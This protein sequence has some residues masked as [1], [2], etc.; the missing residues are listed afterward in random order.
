M[1]LPKN[2]QYSQWVLQSKQAKEKPDHVLDL[3][4]GIIEHKYQVPKPSLSTTYTTQEALATFINKTKEHNK[5]FNYSKKDKLRIENSI[6]LDLHTATGNTL[7]NLDK[8]YD[9][10]DGYVI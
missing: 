5:S 7:E 10:R 4:D 3:Q 6:I 1:P 8:L 2:Y 9:V